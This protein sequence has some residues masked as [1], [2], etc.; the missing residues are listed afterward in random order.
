MAA[1]GARGIEVG[2]DIYAPEKTE[3]NQALFLR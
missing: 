1:I 3:P 2:F